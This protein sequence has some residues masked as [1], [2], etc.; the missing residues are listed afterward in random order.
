M[1]DNNASGKAVLPHPALLYPEGRGILEPDFQVLCSAMPDLALWKWLLGGFSAFTLGAAKTGMPGGGTLA[2][3]M[4]VLVVGNARYAAAWTA[5]I[6]STGDIFAVLY[7]RR[8]ADARKLFSLIPWVLLGGTGGALA[9][10]LDEQLLR[11]MVATIIAIMLVLFVLQRRGWLTNVSRGAWA[12]GIAAGFA[13][14][15]ANAAGPV[16]NMYLLTRKLSK[17]QFVATGAWFFFVVNI[18]KVPVYMWYGLFSLESLAFDLM[19][20]PLVIAGGF[21]GLWLIHRV[22]QPLFE[23]LVIVLTSI[24]LYFLY[25]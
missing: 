11:R 4:M 10:G 13:T 5:P 7:W 12:Y 2:I 1:R 18:A 14:V 20:A 3:P 16:M 6:L 24:S 9:L 15:V 25:R 17:E 19:M 22:P 8:H 23:W 21:A